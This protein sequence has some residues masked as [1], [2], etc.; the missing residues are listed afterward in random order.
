MRKKTLL[1]VGMMLGLV[2]FA[3]PASAMATDGILT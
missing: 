2:A 3:L 1:F